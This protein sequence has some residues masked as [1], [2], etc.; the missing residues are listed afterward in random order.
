[1]HGDVFADDGLLAFAYDGIK[2]LQAGVGCL[3]GISFESY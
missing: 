1:V 2:V 3:H